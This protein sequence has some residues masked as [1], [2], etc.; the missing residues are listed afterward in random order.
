MPKGPVIGPLVIAGALVDSH[1]LR[2]LK[3]IGVRDSKQLTRTKRELLAPQIREIALKTTIIEIQ[4]K[5]IDAIVQRAKRLFK[6][7][8]LEAKV[9]GQIITTLKP[10]IAYVDASDVS[11]ERF[12]SNM[13]EQIP[14]KVRIIAEHKADSKYIIVG[15]ASILAKTVRDQRIDEI[16]SKF[17][18]LGSGYPNDPKTRKFL[19]D[20]L[21][22]HDNYP[23]FVRKSW[24]TA[25]RI[26]DEVRV[27][28]TSLL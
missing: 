25:R 23:E 11:A 7:N 16:S 12:A 10:S 22:K 8:Y 14:F 1:G 20:W 28:Q 21:A 2:R 15:A 13:S 5:E 26:L 3:E 19:K 18:D 6:L 4:P 9:M 17:G 24:K 27:R